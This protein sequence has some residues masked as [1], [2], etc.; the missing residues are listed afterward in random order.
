M[1]ILYKTFNPLTG[2]YENSFENI[3]LINQEAKLQAINYYI[4][5][6]NHS[7]ILKIYTTEENIEIKKSYENN[8][9]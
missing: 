5:N 7:L 3:N 4:S 9:Y 1:S 6:C 2:L 8:L